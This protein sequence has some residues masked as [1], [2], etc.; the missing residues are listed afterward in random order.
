[1]TH[2]IRVVTLILAVAALPA[3]YRTATGAPAHASR[4]AA[5]AAVAAL[6]GR[7]VET[8][9]AVQTSIISSPEVEV[10]QLRRAA[11]LL[12]EAADRLAA[13][14]ATAESAA[15]GGKVEVI[16]V[17]RAY[18]VFGARGEV[19]PILNGL[20]SK[21]L[22]VQNESAVALSGFGRNLKDTN[23]ESMVV[24]IVGFL[25]GQDLPIGTD[26][27]G[28]KIIRGR[29]SRLLAEL[30]G[31]GP[32]L[33]DDPRA[34]PNAGIEERWPQDEQASLLYAGERADPVIRAGKRWIAAR[35]SHD[36]STRSRV[37]SDP[38]A[39]SRPSDR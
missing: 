7:D 17:R 21:D 16:D 33:H 9:R 13:A 39:A 32:P 14:Q 27:A 3:V 34:G 19:V 8:S 38:R 6:D 37:T 31:T 11:A 22:D 18:G 25:E 30:V 10:E 28:H 20:R 4:A 29:L 5:V 12:L 35:T 2:G 1:M 23:R 26:L 36:P 24:A 15:T